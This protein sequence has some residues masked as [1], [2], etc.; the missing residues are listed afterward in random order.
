MEEVCEDISASDASDNG[1]LVIRL[2]IGIN[3]KARLALIHAVIGACY[4]EQATVLVARNGIGQTVGVIMAKRG[5]LH[6]IDRHVDAAAAKETARMQ[7]DQEV[8][9]GFREDV[10]LGLELSD[11]RSRSA[12]QHGPAL[13]R[14]VIDRNT[15][16]RG[17]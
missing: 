15:Q 7:G 11:C 14:R 10:H 12:R 1:T 6:T 8:L 13:S 3:D 5:D 9:G 17:R 16:A 4:G 2:L